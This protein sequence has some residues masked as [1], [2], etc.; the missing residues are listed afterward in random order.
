MKTYEKPRL[1][2][3]LLWLMT[4]A[5]GLIVANN[6]YNQPLLGLIARD[7]GVT[8]QA[9]SRIAML[10]QIGYAAGLLVIVPLGDLL[11]RKR[12]IMA[13]FVLIAASSAGMALSNSLYMAYAF[14]FLIGFTSVIPQIFVPMA[15]GLAE[16]ENRT[17]TIGFVMSGLLLGILGSRIF[18]G[19]IG[20]LMGWR[21]V[22]LIAAGMVLVLLLLIIR[23]LPEV[24]P[25]YKGTYGKLMGS[26]IRF[27][28]TEPALQ[29]AALRGALL[30]A[31]FSTFWTALVFHLS[32]PPFNAGSSI[33]G[34]FGLAGMLGALMA[35]Y[36][37]KTVGKIP[38]SRLMI[39]LILVFLS[40]W[41]VFLVGGTTYMGLIAGVV[42]LD[43]AMQA[44]H[45]MNQSSIFS[46]H[47][48]AN[49]RI[50]TVYMTSYFIGG[51]AGTYVSGVAWQNWGW[52]GVVVTG[53]GLA[54]LAMI[55]HW[56]K[57][58]IYN[59]VLA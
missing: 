4:V 48:E 27:A 8:A 42:V 35:V 49:N 13:D 3:T 26:V 6:Y 23:K 33:A 11:P 7:F 5:S 47:P 34:A 51:A 36:V 38:Y 29:V 16:P 41:G 32:K 43:V 56:S 20:N 30:F 50:N 21:S 9:V 45:V 57:R 1:T 28:R 25:E 18:S 53:A 58:G 44:I 10:T 2:P 55:A 19:F 15:A 59:K 46:L 54:L 12:L 14:S 37:G 40:A 52:H 24:L 31:S 22:F 39:G 17:K